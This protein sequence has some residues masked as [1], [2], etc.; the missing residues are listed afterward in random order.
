MSLIVYEC[1]RADHAHEIRQF[2]AAAQSLYDYFDGRDETAF[3]IGNVNIG[4]ANL[5]GLIVKNDA[6]IIVE[7]KDYEGVV[8][9]RQN[10]DWT[11]DGKVIKGGAGGKSVFEQLRKNQRILRKV[12]GENNYLSEVQRH[13]IKGLV[14]FTKLKSYSDDFD[15]TNK[16]WIYV[17]DLDNMGHKMHEITS[18]DF[19]DYRTGKTHEVSISDEDLFAFLRKMKIDERAMVTDFTDTTIMPQDLFDSSKPHNGKH[20]STA[21]LLAQRTEEVD[22]LRSR[23]EELL[24]QLNNL[25]IDHQKELNEKELLINQQ[26]AEILQ[27]MAD[28]LEA[29]KAT[30]EAQ[31]KIEQL[32]SQTELANIVT[33]E[34]IQEQEAAI[35]E[36]IQ[37]ISQNIETGAL[38]SSEE[39][40]KSIISPIEEE[41]PRKRRFGMKERVLKEFNVGEDSLDT[42]QIGLIERELDKSMIVSGCAG[43]GKSVIAM[44]KAQQIIDDGGDVI[45]IAYTKSLNRYMQQGKSTQIGHNNFYYHWEWIDAGRPSADYLIVDEIQDFSESEVKEFI[46]AARKCFFFF[47]DTAQSIYEGIKKPLSMK[48]LSDMTG[49]AIS[50]LNSNYRL[51]R[52]IAKITQSYVAI[53]ANPYAEAIYQSKE[54]EL[55]HFVG[56]EDDDFLVDSMIELITSKKMKSVGILVPSNERV[57]SLMQS[58]NERKFICEFKY[59]AGYNDKRNRDSLDFTSDKPKLMTY[60]S[61]KGLQFETVILPFYEG[62]RD[63]DSQKALYVAMTRT[64]RFLYVMYIGRILDKPLQDVPE[65]LYLK[66]L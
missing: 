28:K 55:P 10:G 44:Y 49:I 7:F 27:A 22:S 54:Q 66:T 36:H 35:V 50:Y 9:A 29:D 14:V 34:Q 2:G 18:S 41:K 21:T 24:V 56:F 48:E 38:L 16:A 30:L 32:S 59:N 57:I 64:Y 15:R 13:D 23:V 43:S 25:R 53:D 51:P 6:V 3:F 8:V 58:F 4:D 40:S 26:K 12:I 46:A 20:Y 17:T 65:H 45:M 63:K 61:A 31:K 5:D 19:R 33:T 60:H 39:S 11:C 62:A 47:G 42:E 52:P 37:K 1:Q